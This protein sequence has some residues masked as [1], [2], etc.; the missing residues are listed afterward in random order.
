MLWGQIY[1]DKE[2][3]GEKE[4]YQVFTLESFHDKGTLV[5][6]SPLSLCYDTV[7]LGCLGR[8]LAGCCEVLIQPLGEPAR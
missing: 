5:A 7:F 6:V 8:S 1:Q 2:T 3:K 4:S